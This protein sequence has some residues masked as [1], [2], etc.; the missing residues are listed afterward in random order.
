MGEVGEGVVPASP[1]GWTFSSNYWI[2]LVH[3]PGFPL[4]LT[5]SRQARESLA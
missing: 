4:E 5:Q 1:W 3:I 2:P